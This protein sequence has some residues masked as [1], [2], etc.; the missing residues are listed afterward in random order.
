MLHYNSESTAEQ[1]SHDLKHHVR[2][3]NSKHLCEGNILKFWLNLLVVVIMGISPG[4]LGTKVMHVP[5]PYARLIYMTG[6]SKA[7][8]GCQIKHSTL[9]FHTWSFLIL[10]FH[11]IKASIA[12]VKRETPLVS[13]EGPI[14]VRPGSV[15]TGIDPTY[16]G[17]ASLEA[18]SESSVSAAQVALQGLTCEKKTE[19]ILV[20][21]ADLYSK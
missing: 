15:S 2:G 12:L 8:W 19:S 9:E 21:A 1:V 16:R 20:K 17:P 7:W 3:K 14:P 18:V 6:C 13:G 4:G 10:S 11:S 5:A